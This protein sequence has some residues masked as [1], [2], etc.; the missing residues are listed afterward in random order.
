[1]DELLYDAEYYN[2]NNPE[3]MSFN[4]WGE[5]YCVD[6]DGSFSQ[7]AS[8]ARFAGPPDGYKYSTLSLYQHDGYSGNEQWFYD[9]TPST[10][11]D[12]FGKSV[13]VTGCDAWT[14]YE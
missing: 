9:E 10:E 7:R 5:G 2:T 3:L 14:L 1:M 13:I 4:G 6:F 12:N 8:S 11:I